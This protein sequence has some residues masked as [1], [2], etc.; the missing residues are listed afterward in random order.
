MERR[1]AGTI[2]DAMTR[3]HIDVRRSPGQWPAARR[4]QAGIALFVLLVLTGFVAFVAVLNLMRNPGAQDLAREQATQAAL[5]RAKQA[6]ISYAIAKIDEDPAQHAAENGASGVPS[7]PGLLPCPDVVPP[8]V[9]PDNPDRNSDEGLSDVT[10]C[11]PMYVSVIGRLPWRTIGTEPIRDGYGECLWY[12]VSGRHKGGPSIANMMFNW[13]SPGQLFVFA[14][15]GTTRL[16]GNKTSTQAVAAILAPGPTIDSGTAQTRSPSRSN[17]ACPGNADPTNYLEGAV[18]RQNAIPSATPDLSSQLI[19][20]YV[21]PVTKTTLVNDRIVFITPDEIFREMA[22]RERIIGTAASEGVLRRLTRKVAECVAQFTQQQNGAL[23][24]RR[25]MF[26]GR[27][28]LLPASDP[29][30]YRDASRYVDSIAADD[31]RLRGRVPFD[32]SN[33]K[34]HL[35]GMARPVNPH[36]NPPPSPPTYGRTDPQ[37]LT[38]CTHW[39]DPPGTDL[40]GF[41]HWYRNWKDHLFLAVAPAFD[42]RDGN[43]EGTSCAD[44]LGC[45]TVGTT[46]NVAAAVFF[47][48]YPRSASAG[49][50]PARWSADDREDVQRYLD[51]INA[52]RFVNPG[53]GNDFI[54]ADSHPALTNDVAYCLVSA[55]PGAVPTVVAC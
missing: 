7:F 14:Q 25:I 44:P 46:T 31:S 53:S 5:A 50:P 32:V 15:D 20:G 29:F 35:D 51:G 23:T 37:L 47:A 12:I 52:M 2:G 18:A 16:A 17:L 43:G 36:P 30:R 21:D 24:D 9:D 34:S 49:E 19:N 4:E 55:A 3:G 33:T 26:A 8:P 48:G 10:H 13:D 27:L 41:A 28:T 39:A 22:N 54:S 6:L 1:R 42:P 45:L 38:Q 11:G 40:P